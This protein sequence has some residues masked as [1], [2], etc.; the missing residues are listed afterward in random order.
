MRSR[1]K[2]F[3]VYG[4]ELEYMI[5]DRS[6]LNILPI[7][8]QLFHRISGEWTDEVE[9]D[10]I[11]LNNELALHVVE[12]KTSEPARSLEALPAL[13]QSRINDLEER[14][15]A[16]DACLMPTA[17]HPWMDPH[18]EFRI[19]PHGDA[20]IYKKFHEIFDCRGHGWSNLQ[21]TH[22][23]LPFGDDQEFARL[24]AAIRMVLPLIPALAASSPCADGKITAMKD[25][26][27]QTYRNN[28]ARIFSVTGHVIPEA[29]YSQQDYLNL[30]LEPIYNDLSPHDPNGILRHEW[31]NARGAIARFERSSI[32]IRLVDIQEAPI[33]DLAIVW[34]VTSIVR[35]LCSE[36]W[37]SIDQY[38]AVSSRRLKRVLDKTQQFGEDAVIQCPEYLAVLGW[39]ES[40]PPTAQRL[41]KHLIGQGSSVPTVF[42]EPLNIILDQGTLATRI[43][44]ALGEN[45]TK[46]RFHTVYNQLCYSLETG[47]AFIS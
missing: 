18:G 43:V 35:M 39:T 31:A 3:E 5:V 4:V 36:P 7:T 28:A 12:L 37:A 26:R 47:K 8:D 20:G 29:V 9:L 23:N 46:D 40:E 2:L 32:E 17:M 14:L 27:I 24:H 19:W 25:Y 16:W 30:I 21:S 6:T 44:R 11:T 10:E 42:W 41:L 34:A 33:M 1:F 15:K 45:P 13:F 38:N 22:I